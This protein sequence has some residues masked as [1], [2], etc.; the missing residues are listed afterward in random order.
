MRIL[1]VAEGHDVV[2]DVHESVAAEVD[3][4]CEGQLG[5]KRHVH[6]FCFIVKREEEMVE[7]EEGHKHELVPFG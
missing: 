2:A 6:V 5:D 4:E 3:Q 7:S 1:A